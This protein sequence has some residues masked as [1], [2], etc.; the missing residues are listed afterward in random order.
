MNNLNEILVENPIIAAVRSDKNLYDAINSNAKIVFVLY[1]NVMSI[2][3]ICEKLRNAGKIVFIHVDLIDGIRG[4]IFGIQFINKFAKPNGIITTKVSCIKYAKQIGLQTIL[5]I[6]IID[7]L[8]IKTGAKNI[9]DTN[10]NAV[11][12]MPGV[13]IKALEYM[14]RETNVPLIAG[15]LIDKKKD[16]IDALSAG[17]VAISTTAANIWKM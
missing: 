5:R 17:A 8:S 13:A 6:F 12:I 10:P 11:E 3:D 14:K 15:G 4:D 1:G 16:A 2:V 7:S 9:N